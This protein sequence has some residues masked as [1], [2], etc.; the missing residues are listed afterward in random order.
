MKMKTS[1]KIKAFTLSEMIV[2]LVITLI[3]VGLAF[4]V[5][6]LIQKQM[7]GIEQNYNSKTELNMLRQG[8]WVDF[9]TYSNIYFDEK[10]QVLIFSHDIGQMRYIID[11]TKIIRTLDT[12]KISMAEKQFFFEGKIVVSGEIDALKLITSKQNGA[13]EI[14]LYK[15]NTAEIYLKNGF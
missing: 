7:S 4:S 11:N 9:R 13:Q 3:V 1:L 2:V 6:N 14:F 10:A 8:L 12:F 5:L 15:D